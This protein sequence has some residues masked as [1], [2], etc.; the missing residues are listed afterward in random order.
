[1]TS[2]VPEVKHVSDLFAQ[3]V[4][5]SKSLVKGFLSIDSASDS[6][7]VQLIWSKTDLVNNVTPKYQVQHH[8]SDLTQSQPKVF[9]TGFPANY[10][11]KYTSVSPSTKRVVSLT[12]GN[13]KGD[14]EPREGIFSMVL[15]CSPLIDFTLFVG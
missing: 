8:V 12:F 1:M 4:A 7:S 14:D 15:C 5:S 9:V 13:G 6:A 3:V 11:D 10:T 2:H